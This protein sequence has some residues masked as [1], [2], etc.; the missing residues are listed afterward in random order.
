MAGTRLTPTKK[1]LFL[2]GGATLCSGKT[3]AAPARHFFG[4][5]HGS[6]YSQ[7]FPRLEAIGELGGGRVG[8]LST[9]WGAWHIVWIAERSLSSWRHRVYFGQIAPWP[10]H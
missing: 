4:G 10:W 1:S 6:V 2:C 5:T 3:R 8:L 9:P 7:N